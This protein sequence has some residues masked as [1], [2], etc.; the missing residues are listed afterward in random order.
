MKRAPIIR[1]TNCL[2]NGVG[3]R[4]STS[5][6]KI[7]AASEKSPPSKDTWRQGVLYHQGVTTSAGK[8]YW[9]SFGAEGRIW[10]TPDS[11]EKEEKLIEFPEENIQTWVDKNKNGVSVGKYLAY[12][13]PAGVCFETQYSNPVWLL[14]GIDFN[15]YGRCT[16]R[17]LLLARR[18]SNI[19]V[20]FFESQLDYEDYLVNR[21]L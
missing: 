18:M 3:Y 9:S 20:V 11:R 5:L 2:P 15:A 10:S 7:L 12:K 8:C 17:V 19:E 6:S 4:A 21:A 13:L 14:S 1:H 16:P